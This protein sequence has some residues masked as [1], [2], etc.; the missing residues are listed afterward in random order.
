MG[1]A[2]SGPEDPQALMEKQRAIML[3]RQRQFEQKRQQQLAGAG[4]VSPP[5]GKPSSSSLPGSKISSASLI[6]SNKK[7]TSLP[8]QARSDARSDANMSMA[9]KE[10][11]PVTQ[12]SA[13]EL[14]VNSVNPNNYSNE[15]KSSNLSDSTSASGK[16]Y[17]REQ[18]SN[19]VTM[20]KNSN[21][22]ETNDEMKI[23]EARARKYTIDQSDPNAR[24]SKNIHDYSMYAKDVTRRPSFNPRPKESPFTPEMQAAM[25]AGHEAM[26]AAEAEKKQERMKATT[27]KEI[28]PKFEDE[29]EEDKNIRATN[30]D[31]IPAVIPKIQ[32]PKSPIHQN[33][34]SELSTD[35]DE[36]SEDVNTESKP[37]KSAEPELPKN[38]KEVEDF[39]SS[40]EDESK[41]KEQPL[42]ENESIEGQNA[43]KFVAK[44]DH[45]RRSKNIHDLGQCKQNFPF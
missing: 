21:L 42:R 15:K 33:N 18:S 8:R 17:D 38:D 32:E 34:P 23:D 45:D 28:L 41:K 37:I 43:S 4:Q 9:G 40:V 7:H 44:D 25:R 6:D 14:N 3:E 2:S 39:E 29:E 12:E 24:R 30:I 5:T 1:C 19:T 36:S 31:T 11:R 16:Q 26:M 13:P 10:S 22:Q 35:K 20:K 27:E